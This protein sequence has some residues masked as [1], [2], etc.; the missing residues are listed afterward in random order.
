MQVP[1]TL[2]DAVCVRSPVADAQAM[3][4]AIAFGEA[5]LDVST[6]TVEV[7]MGP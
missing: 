4:D 3:A 7:L 1:G 5:R 6:G 2:R